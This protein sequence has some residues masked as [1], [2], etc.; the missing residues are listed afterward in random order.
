MP[1]IYLVIFDLTRFRD[2]RK[3]ENEFGSFGADKAA[4]PSRQ[5]VTILREGP[6]VNVHVLTWCDTVSN[7]NRTLDR[8][9]MGEFEMR[10]LFQMSAADSSQLIDSP[11]AGRLGEN[12]AFFYSEE[13]GR[14]EKFRPYSPPEDEDLAEFKRRFDAKP[15]RPPTV[16]GDGLAPKAP[17][18]AA[19]RGRRLSFD[20]PGPFE[21][22]KGDNGDQ[23]PPD[24]GAVRR[25]RQARRRSRRCPPPRITPTCPTRTSGSPSSSGRSTSSGEQ[26]QLRCGPAP[27]RA[28]YALR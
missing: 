3:D 22:L 23:P 1:A 26:E 27:A 6:A 11:A 17:D 25:A 18:R 14:L 16:E 21:G 9:G 24:D 8:Q 20:R 5:F 28:G 15:K 2:L 19:G 13:Q 10:V 12:R 7:L 4:S